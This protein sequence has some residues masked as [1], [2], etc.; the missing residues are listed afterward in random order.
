MRSGWWPRTDAREDDRSGRARRA[1]DITATSVLWATLVVAL[2]VPLSTP[3]SALGAEATLFNISGR[4]WGHGIGMCQW[5][6]YGYALHGWKYQQILSHYY[7]GVAFG[8]IP[9]AT[10][11]ILLK[12]CQGSVGVTS[13]APF[14]A[15]WTSGHVGIAAGATAIVTWSGGSY[16]LVTGSQTFAFTNP[17]MFTP[18]GS[19]LA[20]SR[21]NTS[22]QPGVGTHYRGSLRVVRF[23]GGLSVINAVPIKDYLRGVVPCEVSSRWPAEALKA[24]AVASRSYAATH[25]GSGG[26]FDLY[27]DTR[28]Q[29]Y[30]GADV[31]TAATNAAVAATRGVVP[32]YAGKPIV[33]F[34][35]STSGGYTE[36][37]ENV[38][39]TAPVPYLKGV[40][41]PYDSY[42][43]FHIWP[44]NPIRKTAT[45]VAA[46]LGS[47]CAPSGTLQTIYVVRC[48]VSPRVVSADAVGSAGVRA[49][50]GALLRA[51][52]GLRDTWFTVRTL[53]INRGPSGVATYGQPFHLTGRVFPALS[54]GALILNYR[55]GNGARRT[56]PVTA[57]HL[58]GGTLKLP[59]GAIATFDSYSADVRSPPR[60]PTS[61]PSAPTSPHR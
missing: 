50:S 9:N 8:T 23:T 52:L 32:T 45:A 55:A 54:S 5:G 1:R 31:E 10:I 58:V 3:A 42:S 4:G 41:D 61:S 12:E 15:N 18:G 38:W 36:N 57:D 35:F 47:T 30:G 20:L 44:D 25:L 19:L 39:G 17:V 59:G 34:Y 6:A 56:A 29:V 40:P 7:T 14:T 49:L 43:P 24:Q 27:S 21:G 53:S 11:R 51:R 28:S 46:A 16:R 22:A 13:S 33:A 26:A 37:I 2:V 48:G 60:P